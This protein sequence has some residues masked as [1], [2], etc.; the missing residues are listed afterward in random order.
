[1]TAVRDI[2]ACKQ[3]Y[4]F[5]SN[6]HIHIIGNPGMYPGCTLTATGRLKG[7]RT[8]TKTTAGFYPS[9]HNFEPPLYAVQSPIL[10]TAHATIWCKLVRRL[11]F[12][13]FTRYIAAHSCKASFG[14]RHAP[15]SK[16]HPFPGV[17]T[18]LGCATLSA[19]L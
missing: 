1:M 17:M 8:K 14:I 4:Q 18:Y 15:L 13:P 7:D 19:T 2:S 9:T 3:Q 10:E 6:I 16:G 11:I 12:P 5:T